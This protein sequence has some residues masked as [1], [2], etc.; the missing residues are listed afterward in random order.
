M[1]KDIINILK[2]TFLRHKGVRTFRY[3]GDDL[4]N[5][6]NNHKGFQ[7]Y[8]DDVSYSEYNVTTNIVKTSFEIYILG[9][10]SVSEERTIL[11]VQNEAYTVA[12]NVM[13]YIDDNREW[14]NVLNVY[15]WSILSLSH[16]T[17]DDCAGVK[18]SLVLQTPSPLNWCTLESNFNV[19][20][21]KAPEEPEITINKDEVG[22]ITLKPIKLPLKGGC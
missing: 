13:A 21:Y 2:D 7:V 15:D 12:V 6:Q 10:P 1:I 18:L 3:Q 22:E 9:H 20:P 11:D 17:S 19:E 5:A 4:N 14:S 8:I 16:Y